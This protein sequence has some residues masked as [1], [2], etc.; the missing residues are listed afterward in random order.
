M[1]EKVTLK[2][3]RAASYTGND[4]LYFDVAGDWSAY[5]LKL[6]VKPNKNVNTAPEFIKLNALNGGNDEQFEAAYNTTTNKTRI[7]ITLLS[8]DSQD[9]DLTKYYFDCVAI[10]ASDAEK[11]IPLAKGSLL[12]DLGVY[13]PLDEVPSPRETI[14]LV[15]LTGVEDNSLLLI[16][17]EVPVPVP[18]ADAKETLGITAVEEDI[19]TLESGKVDKETGKGL[20][21]E[22]F[23]TEIKNN[24][25]NSQSFEGAVY[26]KNLTGISDND[27]KINIADIV[28]TLTSIIMNRPLSAAQGKVLKDL[29]DALSTG[30]ADLV[31]G[32]VP[33]TQLPS[34][35][36]DVLEFNNFAALP[37]TGET[38]KIYVTKDTNLTYRWSGTGY[39]E[40]SQSLALGEQS[41]TAYRGDRGKTA[42]DHS[43][44]AHAPADANN[45]V[46]P[47]THP[48]SMIVDD[49]THRFVTDTEKAIWNSA[50]S[51]SFLQ[52]NYYKN[53]LII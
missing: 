29:I 30:K 10:D 51:L 35:V 32:T 4:R 42:Y 41:S 52:G 3:Y 45:Y 9:F 31:N 44:T 25:A 40:V 15:D 38:G 48:A 34:Y 8:E 37:E 49:T 6:T 28:N 47:S 50:I 19:S 16:Q 36:D 21:E 43:Q 53:L 14:A 22:D 24:I 17:S 23:T 1:N 18:L 12:V 7:Y 26:Y 11:V 33:S 20:S 46:H 5:K 39:V 2:I 13:H 27:A